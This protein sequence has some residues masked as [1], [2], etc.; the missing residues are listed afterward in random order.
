LEW[1]QSLATEFGITVS[2]GDV[3]WSIAVGLL[4]GGFCLAVGTW[5]ARRVGVLDRDAPAGETL[6]VGLASGLLV[7]AAWWAAIA[8]GG[9]S[10]FTPVAVG[11]A[12]ATG[13]ALVRPAPALADDRPVE[14][15]A[16]GS[17]GNSMVLALVLGGAFIVAVALLYGSTMAPSPRDGLQPVES[18]DQAYYSIFGAD[19]ADTGT[20]TIFATSGFSDLD[21]LPPQTWYHWGEMWLASVV[22]KVFGLSALGARHFVVLPILLLAAAALTGTLVRRMTRTA[23][24]RAFTFGFL[25]CLL[26]APVPLVADSFFGSWAVGLIFGITLYG[27]A[28][29]AVLFAFYGIAVLPSRQGTW[30]LAGF[31]GSAAAMILPAHLVIAGLAVV[32]IGGVWGVRVLRSLV[33]R[34]RLPSIPSTWHHTLIWTGAGLLATAGWGLLTGHGFGG[35]GVSASVSPFNASWR[36]A[37]ALTVIGAGGFLAIAGAWVLVRNDEP[38][39]ASLYVGT[40]VLLAASAFAWGARLGDYNM[41]H[42]Y[43]GGIAVFATPVAAIAVWSIWMRL[44]RSR[45]RLLAFAAVVLCLAQIELGVVLSVIRLQGFGPGDYPAI[46]LAILS[47]V[48]DLPADARLAYACQ[49]GE[50]V[51]YWEP[52]LLS[53][54]AHAARRV[55]PMCFEAETL[56]GLT[57]TAMSLDVVSPLFLT[58]PQRKLYPTA[59]ASPSPDAVVAF[60]HAHGID[61]IYADGVHPN[62]LVPDATPVVQ[63]GD[64]QVL[65]IP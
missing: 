59:S 6:G 28:A 4:F 22:I 34:R 41:F 29:V 35:S 39:Q 43:F 60:M 42:L 33:D 48:R 38:V 51:A 30:A 50:E 65:R 25:A 55:V 36:E 46:P 19:L 27:L 8:S 49:P 47:A 15:G 14:D 31:A 63:V 17:D 61:Y 13:L 7:L 58:A 56:G 21:G 62:V 10:A 24:R 44:R 16:R 18:M 9:R 64:F 2:N 3:W 52:R 37:V 1:L 23:S 40:A 12:V 20:E 53:I 45:R 5:V 26:L 11:F 54:D 57:G 32:G